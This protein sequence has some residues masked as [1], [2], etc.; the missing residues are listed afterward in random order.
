MKLSAMSTCSRGAYGAGIRKHG[1]PDSATPSSW[2]QGSGTGR[3]ATI[4]ATRFQTKTTAAGRQI[5]TFCH[6][7]PTPARRVASV[8]SSRRLGT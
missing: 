2:P 5:A 7:G 4:S 8:A 6:S 1:R 3:E